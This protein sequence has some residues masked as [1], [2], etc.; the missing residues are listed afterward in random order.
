MA[1]C[2]VTRWSALIAF[3]ILLTLSIRAQESTVT[4]LS[5][6]GSSPVE[7]KTLST[8]IYAP[9]ARQAR[10]TGKVI[11]EVTI[12]PDGT[13]QSGEV[14]SGHPILRPSALYSA[15]NSKYSCKSCDSAQKHRIIYDFSLLD[16]HDCCSD[17]NAP[18][19]ISE[20]RILTNEESKAA[21][22][23]KVE[24][25][26]VCICDPASTVTRRVRSIKCLYLWKCA[27]R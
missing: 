3:T 27:V 24:A 5:A 2:A 20:A 21:T 11:V 4:Q 19:P 6:D 17:I 18:V 15:T 26:P 13:F 25:P 14:I 10:I 22:N 8:P 9:L 1:I 16:G 12:C 23:I 7:L